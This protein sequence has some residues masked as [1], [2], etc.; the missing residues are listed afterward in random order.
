MSN[1]VPLA[2]WLTRY[3]HR[4]SFEMRL[5][6]A[7]DNTGATNAMH[8]QIPPRSFGCAPTIGKT[9]RSNIFCWYAK[10]ISDRY[11]KRRG[12]CIFSVACAEGLR[13]GQGLSPPGS[14]QVGAQHSHWPFFIYVLF[15]ESPPALPR[16]E[17]PCTPLFAY[18]VIW[19][20]TSD[21]NCQSHQIGAPVFLTYLCSLWF[22][23]NTVFGIFLTSM[24]HQFLHTSASFSNNLF[25]AFFQK[26]TLL[27]L[28]TALFL[29]TVQM[30]RWGWVLEKKTWD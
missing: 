20:I 30:S 8:G 11:M 28:V 4:T 19:H 29:H 9:K 7:S 14:F 21:L 1:F 6:C 27:S 25:I 26:D 5:S 2:G 13:R 18:L 24:L 23:H 3:V 12:L 17:I 15:L 10:Y 16:N 22:L